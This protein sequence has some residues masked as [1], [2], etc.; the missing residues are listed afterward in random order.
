[1][2]KSLILV[3]ALSALLASCA[4]PAPEP[5]GL[6]TE[7]IPAIQPP[8][9]PDPPALVELNVVVPDAQPFPPAVAASLEALPPPAD[10]IW[11]RIRKGFA[12]PDLDD[13]LVAKWEEWYASRPDYV[14]RMI[15]RS[16][17]YLYHIVVEV[18]ERRMP[19][20]IALLPMIESAYNPNALS[21]SRAS[22]IWQFIPSTGTHYGLKQTFWFDSRRDVIAGTE[23]ALTYLMKLHGDFDDW[24]LAL[25]AYNW[26]EGNVAK[27][28]ALNQKKGLPGNYESLKMPDETRN[29]L[30]KLQ[31]VKNIVS[32]PGKYGIVLDDIPDAPYFAVVHTTKRMDVKRAAELAEMPL[33]EFQF[34]NPHFNRPVIAGADEYTILLPIDKAELFAAK[35]DLTDQPLVS[36][37][38]YRMRNGETLPQVAAKFG[39]PV[40]SLRA[41]N[42]LGTK[43][44]VPT[45][46]TLLVPSTRASSEAELGLSQAVFTTVPQGRTF[47]YRVNRGDTLAG[48][49][50]RYDVS[51]Q[52][53]RRWNGLAQATVAPG[54][55]LRITSDRAPNVGK[56]KR[57][58]GKKGTASAST[59]AP[60]KRAVAAPAS[61]KP[62][63][64]PAKTG[65]KAAKTGTA[66]GG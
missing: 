42:G 20:E 37:Q 17:R 50:G 52:D 60:Q 33:E 1:L 53:I 35:L 46:H 54:Q 44:K 48:I 25:A 47:Y 15:D 4:T 7:P 22:G 6:V 26:G 16:R 63:P 5:L 9:E 13:P 51:V 23:G 39:L 21:T 24:Q 57:A 55:S 30:P 14:A 56:A 62:A 49:A 58:T 2:R 41:V 12:M 40:E 34:L 3:L 32:D 10:D 8:P 18:D 36:W 29:Y 65:T 38:A 66:A 61:H 31:A 64:T 28:I 45:G 43:A 19:T 59:K 27:A 11:V